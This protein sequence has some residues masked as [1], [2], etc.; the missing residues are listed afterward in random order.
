MFFFSEQ[1]RI[2]RQNH[3]Q[4]HKNNKDSDDRQDQDHNDRQTHARVGSLNASFTEW[5]QESSYDFN[6]SF[7]MSVIV[8]ANPG[9]QR[10][11]GEVIIFPTFLQLFPLHIYV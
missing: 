7:F 9:L 3:G 4:N 10:E 8:P 5:F 1:T 2:L 6:E 11:L